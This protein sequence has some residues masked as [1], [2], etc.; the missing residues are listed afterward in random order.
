MSNFYKTI[1]DP[2]TG[3]Y[4]RAEFLDFGHAGYK[5]R[6]PDGKLYNAK[7]QPWQK[8]PQ[9]I[10]LKTIAEWEKEKRIQLTDK[11]GFDLNDPYLELRV[12]SQKGF[13]DRMAKCTFVRAQQENSSEKLERDAKIVEKAI[14]VERE[15]NGRLKPGSKL[16]PAGPKPGYKHFKSIAYRYLTTTKGRTRTGEEV[17]LDE[18]MI[19]TA[20]DL[21]LR[22]NLKA[23]Q[24]LVE[25]IDGKPKE[26][27]DLSTHVT[28]EITPERR[29]ELIKLLNLQPK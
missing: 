16:N 29:Q 12:W 24:F 20:V 26:S 4:E 3:R 28:H 6:F 7:D 15:E 9:D 13:E 11:K 5:V 22:G 19:R 17:T 10:I 1:K 21:A 18:A 25:A 23:I 8:P 14:V 27:L 2:R